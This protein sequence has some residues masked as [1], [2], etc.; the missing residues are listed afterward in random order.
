[1][2]PTIELDKVLDSEFDTDIPG[3]L[4]SPS[5]PRVSTPVCSTAIGILS[6][7]GKPRRV[8]IY[9]EHAYIVY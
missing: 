6:Y 8:V 3:G 2:H 1:M 4:D 5:R 7:T 9:R